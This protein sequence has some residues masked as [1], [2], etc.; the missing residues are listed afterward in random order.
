MGRQMWSFLLV[1]WPSARTRMPPRE[2]KILP[3]ADA[4]WGLMTTV[5]P[6]LKLLM[7]W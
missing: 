6:H 2:I 5:I 7:Q 4:T 1:A 3:C